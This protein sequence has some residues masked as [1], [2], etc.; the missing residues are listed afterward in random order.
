M[1][2]LSATEPT[3]GGINEDFV[4]TGPTWAFILD[5]ATLR[6]DVETGCIHDV[7]WFVSHLGAELARLLSTSPDRALDDTLAD[8]IAATR[9]LH[10]HA[11]DLDNPDSPSATVVAVRACDGQ[12]DYLTVAD[13]PLVVDVDGQVDVITDDRTARLSDYSVAGVREA[14]NTP[15]GFYVAS[16]DP[17]AAY[18]AVRGSLPTTGVHRAA[19]LSDGAARLVERFQVADWPQLLDVLVAEGPIELIRRTRRAECAET[20]AERAGRR[21]KKHDDATVVLV[22]HLNGV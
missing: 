1:Q 12:L 5:G 19:L 21:G 22:T 6:D 7:P 8:G 15:G 20:E 14:R 10:E 2:I 18:Q 4:M 9:C 16:T 11:C 17:E 3:P 13:S